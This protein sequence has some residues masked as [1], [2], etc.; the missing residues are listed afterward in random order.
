M[1]RKTP[2]DFAIEKIRFGLGPDRLVC[3]ETD[4]IRLTEEGNG[5]LFVSVEHDFEPHTTWIHLQ[6]DELEMDFQVSFN[7]QNGK[8]D[9][10]KNVKAVNKML[11]FTTVEQF[12]ETLVTKTLEFNEEKKAQMK[13]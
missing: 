11:K 2:I 12:V 3:D 7:A 13:S 8:I 1:G 4:L 10:D 5:N 9:R 6:S